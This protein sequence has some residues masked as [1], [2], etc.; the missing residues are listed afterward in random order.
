MRTI[1]YVILTSLFLIGCA[2]AP[3]APA[4]KV[5]GTEWEL[6]WTTKDGSSFYY[7]PKSTVVISKDIFRFWTKAE[8]D[9]GFGEE[10]GKKVKQMRFL[11]D[12]N[13]S[14]HAWRQV[15][16][17]YYD[18]NGNIVYR[19]LET[20]N[21][22]II[23]SGKMESLYNI[24]CTKNSGVPNGAKKDYP[25]SKLMSEGNDKKPDG[26]SKEYYKNG[27]L[28]V[29]SSWKDGKANGIWKLYDENGKILSEESFKDDKREGISK[30]YQANGKIISEGYFKDG[31][32][33]GITKNYYENGKLKNKTN[34][35][36][37]KREGISKEYYENGK[38]KQAVN[39]KDGKQV[40]ITKKCYGTEA[41][42][43]QGEYYTG[44][45]PDVWTYLDK[46]GDIIENCICNDEQGGTIQCP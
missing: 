32:L 22:M 14:T 31:N 34:Y 46:D 39:Y 23:S 10:G 24:F 25:N 28:M 27:Q 15:S 6:A 4:F 19:N 11:F 13:C 12:I 35:K 18:F 40:G 33:E 1:I 42:K 9:N 7:N 26:I 30:F 5:E 20:T 36:A 2:T 43:R 38:L 44:G 17:V 21:W 45:I 16:Y 29:E 3:T 8:N 37:G 41:A